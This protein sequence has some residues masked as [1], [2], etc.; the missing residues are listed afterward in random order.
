MELVDKRRSVG[1]RDILH[2]LRILLQGLVIA[3]D[4]RP[5]FGLLDRAGRQPGHAD[6]SRLG[7]LADAPEAVQ[8]GFEPLL[9]EL[10]VPAVV[11]AEVH[12]HGRGFESQHVSLETRVAARRAVTADPHVVEFQLPSRK[13]AKCPHFQVIAVEVLLGDTITHHGNHITILEK[14][15]SSLGRS[16]QAR[17]TRQPTNPLETRRTDHIPSFLA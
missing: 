2:A 5:G 15:V 8:V 12:G 6:T 9:S 1:H 11:H 4:R 10:G 7:L 17:N 16:A 3:L 13:A 14:E